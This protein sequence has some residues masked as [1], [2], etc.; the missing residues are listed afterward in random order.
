VVDNILQRAEFY[1]AYTP[2]QPEASQARC[3]RF[4]FQTLSRRSISEVNA[5]MHDG[6]SATAGRC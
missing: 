3:R 6:A 2:Y 4:E 1:S 5:S